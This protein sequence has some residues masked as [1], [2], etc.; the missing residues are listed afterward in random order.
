LDGII[1]SLQN[2]YHL[3]IYSTKALALFDFFRSNHGKIN[4]ADFS[5]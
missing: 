5:Y 4:L 3:H 2:I 1:S